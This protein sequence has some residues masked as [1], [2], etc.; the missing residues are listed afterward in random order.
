MY[1]PHLVTLDEAA[2][3]LNKKTGVHWTAKSVLDFLLNHHKQPDDDYRPL[4]IFAPAHDALIGHYAIIEGDFEPKLQKYSDWQL[5]PLFDR[6]VLQ[7]VATG[8]TVCSFEEPKRELVNKPSG[9]VFEFIRP[10]DGNALVQMADVRLKG[11]YLEAIYSA[12]CA[13]ACK[14]SSAAEQTPQQRKQE[15]EK[16]VAKMTENKAMTTTKAIE[17]IAKEQGV[18]FGTIKKIYYRV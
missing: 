14:K 11:R 18:K 3:Y 10:I 2:E 6:E 9:I 7:L 17:V 1:I 4:A 5:F 16:R 15:I 12:Y 13:V 8:Q